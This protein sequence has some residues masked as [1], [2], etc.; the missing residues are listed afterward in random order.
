MPRHP[1]QPVLV[2]VEPV[3]MAIHLDRELPHVHRG[4]PDGRDNRGSPADHGQKDLCADRHRWNTLLCYPAAVMEDI[5]EPETLN[6]ITIWL[7]RI[8]FVLCAIAALVALSLFL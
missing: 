5:D 4:V 6:D 7:A 2:V 8:F 3:F 1:L